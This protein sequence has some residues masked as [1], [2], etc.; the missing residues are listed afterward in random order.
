MTEHLGGGAFQERLS[1]RGDNVC[2]V[3]VPVLSA[4]VYVCVIDSE[5]GHATVKEHYHLFL[6]TLPTHTLCCKYHSPLDAVKSMATVKLICVL[7]GGG[8][9]QHEK[10]R[11]RPARNNNMPGLIK[12]HCSHN[13]HTHT[14]THTHTHNHCPRVKRLSLKHHK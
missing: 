14:H 12:F 4:C 5:I 13:H 2:T 8:R 1:L 6:P 10:K 3:C 11:Q 7:E 9:G